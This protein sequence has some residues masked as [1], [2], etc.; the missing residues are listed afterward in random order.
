MTETTPATQNEITRGGLVLAG[1][2]LIG[3]TGFAIWLLVGLWPDRMPNPRSNCMWY[4]GKLFHVRLLDS[5]AEA[6]VLIPG[7]PA[8]V[9]TDSLHPAADSLAKDSTAVTVKPAIS[10]ASDGLIQLN[11]LLLI[12]VALGGFLGN[13]IHI[14]TSFTTFIGSQAY[15]R[16]W[17]LWYFVK[18]FTAAA[19]AVALYFSFRAGFLNYSNDASNLNLYGIMALSFL[20]GLFTDTATL[21]LKEVFEVLFRPKE[22]RPDAIET[23]DK[24]KNG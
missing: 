9:I 17:T 7:V 23:D 24:N 5:C 4:T 8:T 3:A 6:P 11:T 2:L 14:S 20:A 18:P 15:K 1:L 22:Q 21:K 13:L 16:S 12:L 10:P 19:L